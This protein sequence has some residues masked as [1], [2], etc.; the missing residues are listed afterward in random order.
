MT[1]AS[2]DL[3][4]DPHGD[5]RTLE[6]LLPDLRQVQLYMIRM[7]MIEPVASPIDFLLPHLREHALWLRHQE[8]TGALFMSGPNRCDEEWDGSGTAIIRAESLADA[9]RIAET[10]PFHTKGLRVNTAHGWQ[11]SEGAL[12]LNINLFDNRFEIG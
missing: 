7:D 1:E 12:R 10:E 3:T 5:G 8:R 4:F 11:L 2:D 9:R 6:E